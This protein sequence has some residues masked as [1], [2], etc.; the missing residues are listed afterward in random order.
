MRKGVQVAVNAKPA[1]RVSLCSPNVLK[2][3]LRLLKYLIILF[4]HE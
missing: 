2:G 3:Y 1:F 4:Q